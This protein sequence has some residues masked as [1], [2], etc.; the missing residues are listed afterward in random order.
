M[1]SLCLAPA[2][3]TVV[4]FELLMHSYIHQLF[5]ATLVSALVKATSGHPVKRDDGRRF[6]AMLRF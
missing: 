6:P 5:A 2:S 1:R 4:I 3:C